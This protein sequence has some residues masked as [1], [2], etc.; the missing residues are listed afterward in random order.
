MTGVSR[1]LAKHVMIFSMAN[2]YIIHVHASTHTYIRTCIHTHAHTHTH[3][4]AHTH[5]HHT[6]TG[7]SQYLAK[8]VMISSMA[9]TYIMHIRT[10]THTYTH[11][12]IHTHTHAHPHTHAYVVP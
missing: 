7:V 3:T 6:M 1:Y 2:T 9:N 10:S 12:C 11:T 5:T 8:R 4:H